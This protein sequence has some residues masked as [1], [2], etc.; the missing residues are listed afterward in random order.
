MDFPDWVPNAVRVEVS[1]WTHGNRWPSSNWIATLRKAEA[2][3]QRVKQQW[4]QARHDDALAFERL[5]VAFA[6][7]VEHRDRV[8]EEIACLA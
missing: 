5:R 2:D 3:V 1:G 8:A 6:H 4:E 7:A